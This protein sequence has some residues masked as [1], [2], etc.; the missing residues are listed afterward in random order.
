MKPAPESFQPG[1]L[2]AGLGLLVWWLLQ[3]SV[4][5]AR[6]G[7]AT[8]WATVVSAPWWTY[9]SWLQSR[10]SLGGKTLMLAAGLAGS[11]CLSEWLTLC[12]LSGCDG[13]ALPWSAWLD[14]VGSGFLVFSAAFYSW[15]DRWRGQRIDRD[16]VQSRWLRARLD[17]LTAQLNPH[18]L[19]NT[20]S[21]VSVDI[22]SNPARA[23]SLIEKLSRLLRQTLVTEG[24]DFISLH[25]ELSLCDAYLEIQRIRF[26]E[27]LDYA[28]DIGDAPAS[29][30]VPTLLLQPLV[31]N[32]VKHGV[33]PLAKGGTI[34]LLASIEDTALQL[35]LTNTARKRVMDESSSGVGLSNT[36]QRLE[37]LFPGRHRF[38]SGYDG[39]CWEAAI[40]LPLILIERVSND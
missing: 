40:T 11:L 16:R 37:A 24:D 9:A 12:G 27:R 31:E 35:R 19:F 28:I 10:G 18:F 7:T 5:P 21:A 8:A 6:A 22:E 34:T 4:D 38:W 25:E 3:D 20:L 39:Q 30:Q 32:A 23:Q 15:E 29:A 26:G 36:A 13:Q 33:A 14:R 17:T 2:L 1:P